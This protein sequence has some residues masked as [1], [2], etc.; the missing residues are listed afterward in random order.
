MDKIT[1]AIEEMFGSDID[2]EQVFDAVDSIAQDLLDEKENYPVEKITV[3]V[4]ADQEGIDK[5]VKQ[6]ICDAIGTGESALHDLLIL[7]KSLQHPQAYDAIAKLIKQITDSSIALSKTN[8]P[9]PDKKSPKKQVNIQNN[10]T[11]IHSGTLHEILANKNK[12][13]DDEKF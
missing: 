12:N 3:E 8:A 5:F 2:R 1:K 13:A 9:T 4:P 7:A 6:R 10:Q 11:I